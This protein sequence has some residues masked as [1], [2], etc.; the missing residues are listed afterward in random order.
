MKKVIS[1]LLMTSAIVLANEPMSTGTDSYDNSG[2][3][4]VK[5]NYSFVRVGYKSG[6][7]DLTVEDS[8]STVDFS[9]K[10]KGFEIG[11]GTNN[12]GKTFGWRPI[13]SLIYNTGEASGVVDSKTILIQ[14]EFEFYAQVHKYFAPFVGFSGG[15]GKTSFENS[16]GYDESLTAAQLGASVG[17]SGQ[18]NNSVGYYAKMTAL[19]RN[20]PEDSYGNFLSHSLNETTAGLYFIF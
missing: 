18:F 11:F 7:G 5:K 9:E 8:Y 16:Y 1:S 10:E 2:Y 4:S 19:Y 17:V 3:D 20:H 6:S 12:T 14:G 13:F 15:I